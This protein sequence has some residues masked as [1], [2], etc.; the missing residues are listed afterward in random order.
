MLAGL[1]GQLPAR[2]PL[3]IE[4][5]ETVACDGYQRHSIVFDTEDVMS[6]PAYLLV[7]D[8]RRTPGPAVLAVHG[9]GPGKSIV[10]GL[11]TTDAPNG[12]YAHQ[13]AQAGVCG[14]RSRPAVF[15]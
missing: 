2:V 10:V 3:N 5:L 14:P 13:L 11:E 15:R 1:L 8:D 7:P 9:H 6:V 12:D 4:T